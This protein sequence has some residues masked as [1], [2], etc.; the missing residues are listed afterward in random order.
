MTWNENCGPEGERTNPQPVVATS[1]VEKLHKGKTVEERSKD[2]TLGLVEV[3]GP[4]AEVEVSVG[5]TVNLGNYDSIRASVTVRLPCTATDE[6]VERIYERGSIWA[7]KKL[8]ALLQNATASRGGAAQS[9][10]FG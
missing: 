6:E 3:T 5:Q 10:P 4:A 8:A 9:N 1:T 7:Q 2:Q